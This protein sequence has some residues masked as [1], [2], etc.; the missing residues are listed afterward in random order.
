MFTLALLIFELI[1]FFPHRQVEILQN[2]LQENAYFRIA[3]VV[4]ISLL[5]IALT[6]IYILFALRSRRIY[7]AIYFVVFSVFILSEYSVRHATGKFSNSDLL[8]IAVFAG[9]YSLVLQ[10]AREYVS[11]IAV[12]PIVV[13]GLMLWRIKTD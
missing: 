12:I 2:H 4:T 8:G 6:Y 7:R 13:F 1:V 10:A 3:A 5:S 9:D 11:L